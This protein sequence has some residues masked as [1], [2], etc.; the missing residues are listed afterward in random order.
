MKSNLFGKTG[1]SV[2][3]LGFGAG[4][5]G[6]NNLTEQEVSYLLNTLP[7]IGITLIDTA[8]GYGLSEE[9]IGRHLSHRRPDIVLSTKIG[10]GIPGVHDWTYSAII[11]GTHTALKLLQTDY[12][13]IV[14][15]HSCPMNILQ[16]GEIYEALW[17]MKSEGKIRCIAYSGENEE[18][19]FAVH[20]NF[21]TAI[22]TSLNLFDQRNIDGLCIKAKEFGMGIIAKRP[23]GNRPWR[24]EQLPAGDY[25]EEYWRRMRA[26]NLD[27]GPDPDDTAIRFAVFHT[28]ADTAIAG[29]G[30]PDHIKK[31]AESVEKGPLSSEIVSEYREL[32][33]KFDS[34][35][36]GQI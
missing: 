27:L 36:R 28:G 3:V 7:D 29:S 11:E 24:F 2:S 35:W 26:M 16:M 5:I 17:K 18:L 32:F 23:L 10:Y 6:G 8:R 33:R 20:R 14:H 31:L 30:K 19:E 25:C 15:L 4:H 22:Q 9:R 12:I 13:D 21:F 34:N 1:I